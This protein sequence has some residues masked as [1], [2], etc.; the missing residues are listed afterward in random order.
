MEGPTPLHPDSPLI[1]NEGLTHIK[2][3]DNENDSLLLA[4]MLGYYE[5][6]TRTASQICS[7]LMSNKIESVLSTMNPTQATVGIWLKDLFDETQQNKLTS[8]ER[9]AR[10]KNQLYKRHMKSMMKML[11]TA[12]FS[13]K[14]DS[15][16]RIKN[17][18][19]C[20]DDKEILLQF[21]RVF[22]VELGIYTI[23]D[24]QSYERMVYHSP[25]DG[26]AVD[27]YM[28]P[29][30]KRSPDYGL[31]YHAEIMK[32]ED[33]T[34]CDT[35]KF[36]F[37]CTAG[38]DKEKRILCDMTTYEARRAERLSEPRQ[39]TKRKS[40]P[41]SMHHQF[42]ISDISHTS[43]LYT[44]EAFTKQNA[45]DITEDMLHFALLYGLIENLVRTS[46]LD[47]L[48]FF[49]MKIDNL[50]LKV[51][52]GRQQLFNEIKRV[53]FDSIRVTKPVEMLQSNL[54][55]PNFVLALKQAFIE[56]MCRVFPRTSRIPHELR[57]QVVVTRESE[58]II[59]KFCEIFNVE[60]CIYWL[61]S[62]STYER[63]EYFSYVEGSLII[64]IFQKVLPTKNVLTGFL[65]YEEHMQSDRGVLL[66][67]NS[68]PFRGKFSPVPKLV[69]S[70]TPDDFVPRNS[71]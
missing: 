3:I 57:S 5:Q 25:R 2:P 9:Q 50:F 67:Y 53:C 4:I 18:L 28:K 66:N 31:I 14:P 46:S 16:V 27:I 59:S 68:F 21:C 65:Y 17:G 15:I 26:I 23:R 32:Y 8:A 34:E 52:E 42:G 19:L 54:Q 36:P 30:S 37:T 41:V 58:E 11:L 29:E 24:S 10:L 7:R 39:V 1:K 56:L 44:K 6:C 60:V 40:I 13:T 38:P 22:N 62:E 33:G 48:D 63:Y 55:N 35:T 61:T 20:K 64:N 43:I 71:V 70:I 69:Y 45:L 49:R 47:D 12:E 51:D